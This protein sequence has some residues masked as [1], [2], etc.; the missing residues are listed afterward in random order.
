MRAVISRLRSMRLRAN[1]LPLVLAAMMLRALI[2]VGFMPGS[3][4]GVS[5]AASMCS[6]QPG[7]TE[8]IEIPGEHG[9][10]HCE[11]CVASPLGAAPAFVAPGITAA[12]APALLPTTVS[13]TRKS[14]LARAQTARA[15]PRA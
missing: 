7:K 14:F 8:T 12:A 11:Y 3:E 2:P 10:P 9:K 6:T 5:L 13:Q 1:V 4:D 15:P